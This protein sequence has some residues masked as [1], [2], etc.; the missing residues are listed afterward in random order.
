MGFFVWAL[1]WVKCQKMYT[2]S[3]TRRFF[4][5]KWC[6]CSPPLCENVAVNDFVLGLCDIFGL[7]EWNVWSDDDLLVDLIR[8]EKIPGK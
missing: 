7:F 6:A 5:Q 2:Y 8:A 1:K 3:P 4:T